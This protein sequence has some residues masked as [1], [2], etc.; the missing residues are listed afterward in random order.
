MASVVVSGKKREVVIGKRKISADE[1]AFIATGESIDLQIN[2]A[3]AEEL[4]TA[5]KKRFPPID[6]DKIRVA[7]DAT[8]GHLDRSAARGVL[9]MRAL[10]FLQNRAAVRSAVVEALVDLLNRD[11]VP[12]LPAF[13]ATDAEIMTA[14]ADIFPAAGR[15]QPLFFAGSNAAVQKPLSELAPD[16]ALPELNANEIKRTI[17]GVNASQAVFVIAAARASALSKVHDAVAVLS[18][19]AANAFTEPFQQAY[20][21][22]AR[23]HLGAMEVAA[24]LRALLDGSTCVNKA[25]RKTQVRFYDRTSSGVH[26]LSLTAQHLTPLFPPFSLSPSP[27]GPRRSA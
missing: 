25:K 23:P 17:I 20:Y 16:V 9:L 24:V 21:D 11:L 27:A 14:V 7:Y 5:A 18:L 1:F 15:T 26:D 12:V 8:K 10:S 19:E 4:D 2:T 6:V 22:V 3:C 13:P